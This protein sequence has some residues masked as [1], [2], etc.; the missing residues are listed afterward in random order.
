MLSPPKK[1]TLFVLFFAKYFEIKLL[2]KKMF[3]FKWNRKREK[4]LLL[5]NIE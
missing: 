3:P 4:K 1:K 5:A 2:P